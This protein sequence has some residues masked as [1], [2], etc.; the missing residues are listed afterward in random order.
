[1][2]LSNGTALF[3]AQG[4]EEDSDDD[5]KALAVATAGSRA[6]GKEDIYRAYS[7]GVNSSKKKKQ[8]KLKRVIASAKRHAREENEGK[9]Q[10]T[11]AALQVS[12]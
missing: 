12:V 8:A 10:A 9:Q 7:K 11:F 3:G 5:S 6:V 4:E 2:K 1:M